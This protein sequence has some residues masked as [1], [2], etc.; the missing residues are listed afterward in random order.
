MNV[1]KRNDCANYCSDVNRC[2]KG[3]CDDCQA[4]ESIKEYQKSKKVKRY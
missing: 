4:F 3:L 2:Y 1:E